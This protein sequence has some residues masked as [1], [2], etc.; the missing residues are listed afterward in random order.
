MM[1]TKLLSAILVLFFF[2]ISTYAQNDKNVKIEKKGN[3]T[4]ATYYYDTG[5][6]E[7]QGTFNADGELHGVWTSYDVEGIKISVGQY[8][9]GLKNGKWFFWTGETLK[10]VDYVDSRIV[11]VVEW[12]D[13]SR[14][15]AQIEKI[16]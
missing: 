5:S 1:K 10:E 16:N 13:K 7:Q 12:S 9:N 11:N 15:D 3:L 14:M 8:V 2:G 6:I 4:E